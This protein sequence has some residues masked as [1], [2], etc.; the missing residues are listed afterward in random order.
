MHAVKADQ[1]KPGCLFVPTWVGSKLSQ[2]QWFC[3]SNTECEWAADRRII[4]CIVN[5]RVFKSDF[6]TDMDVLVF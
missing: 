5:N 1:L 6:P 4:G 3:F 2:V